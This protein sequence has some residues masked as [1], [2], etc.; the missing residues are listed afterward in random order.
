M[1]QQLGIPLGLLNCVSRRNLCSPVSSLHPISHCVPLRVR[2]FLR[3][4]YLIHCACF[5]A[6][7]L[8]QSQFAFG[9]RLD[10]CFVTLCNVFFKSGMLKMERDG[11]AKCETALEPVLVCARAESTARNVH[12]VGRRFRVGILRQSVA[13]SIL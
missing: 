8:K 7:E 10:F 12:F 13:N 4:L 2:V 6:L 1:S 9:A 5:R 3:A 11:K